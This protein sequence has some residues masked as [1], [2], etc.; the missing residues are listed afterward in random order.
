VSHFLV[1][2]FALT[3]LV[4]L[5]GCWLGWQLLRQNG[6]MLFRLEEIEQRLD[7]LEFGEE[8]IPMRGEPDVP[9]ISPGKDAVSHATHSITASPGAGDAFLADDQASR[10][11]NRSLGRSKINRD[12]LQPG[13]QAPNFRL[14]RLD[15]RGELSLEEF[16]GCRVLLVFSDPHCGPCNKLAPD[17]ETFHRENRSDFAVLMI[18]RGDPKENREKVGEHGL[19]F[20]VVLQHHWEISRRYAMFATPIAYP[21]D[22]KGLIACDVAV[23]VQQILLLLNKVPHCVAKAYP[24]Q[25]VE[26]PEDAV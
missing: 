4:V 17:L 14:P 22:E 2:A 8:G 21:I 13:T 11:R 16:R 18:S 3:W 9:G 1:P 5:A 6:R 20:P 24:E 23:G 12:G 15:G 19:T 10:F 26:A 7:E 25:N